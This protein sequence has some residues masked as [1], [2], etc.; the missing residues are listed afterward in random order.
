MGRMSTKY[1]VQNPKNNE[2][3]E[4]FDFITDDAL[5][6]ALTTANDTFKQWRE[7]SFSERAEVLRKVAKLFDEQRA[8]QY[9]ALYA[10]YARLHD[11]FGRGGNQVMHRLKEI[12]RQAHLR[13]RESTETSNGGNGAHL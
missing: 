5:E 8:E 13:A 3:V 10:E 9:D 6:T 11:Y 4:S 7:K 12:R 2:I 1:R